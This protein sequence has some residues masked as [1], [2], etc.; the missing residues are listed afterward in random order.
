MGTWGPGN[1]D[2]DYALDEIAERSAELTARILADLDSDSYEADSY[3]YVAL[4][5]D[6]ETAIALHAARLFDPW[7]VPPPEVFAAKTKQWLERWSKSIVQLDPKDGFVA[8]RRAAIE[9]TFARFAALHGK[10]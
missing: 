10:R 8:R 7:K 2:S 1:L 5:V 6:L 9:D 3:A 4:F